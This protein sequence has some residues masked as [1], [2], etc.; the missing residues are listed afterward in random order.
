MEKIRTFESQTFNLLPPFLHHASSKPSRHKAR[1]MCAMSGMK[2]FFLG[3]IYPAWGEFKQNTLPFV[4]V[5]GA[6]SILSTC[7]HLCEVMT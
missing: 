7:D 5:H 3:H 4:L 1:E 6:S 2:E